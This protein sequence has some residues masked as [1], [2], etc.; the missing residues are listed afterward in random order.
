MFSTWNK[1]LEKSQKWHIYSWRY[2]YDTWSRPHLRKKHY[3]QSFQC[4]H[5]EYVFESKMNLVLH[6]NTVHLQKCDNG[7]MLCLQCNDP[8]SGPKALKTHIRVVHFNYL[9]FACEECGPDKRFD[10]KEKLKAHMKVVHVQEKKF[11][12]DQCDSRFNN[13]DKLKFHRKRWHDAGPS[14]FCDF[15]GKKFKEKRFLRYSS[16]IHSSALINHII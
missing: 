7:Q 8:F 9:P 5:C 3:A 4:S 15:C 1:N 2:T 14:Y 16:Y 6:E 11:L 12:C 10:T 13:Y